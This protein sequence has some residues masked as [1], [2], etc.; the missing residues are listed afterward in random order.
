[1]TCC[2]RLFQVPEGPYSGFSSEKIRGDL[3]NKG[4]MGI[5]FME[6]QAQLLGGNLSIFSEPRKGTEVIL[7]IDL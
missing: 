3:G 6:E 7:E 2:A 5:G 1:M 4:N